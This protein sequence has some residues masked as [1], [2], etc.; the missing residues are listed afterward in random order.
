MKTSVHLAGLLAAAAVTLAACSSGMPDPDEKAG[1]GTGDP[2][3]TTTSESAAESPETSTSAGS[4]G[5]TSADRSPEGTDASATSPSDEEDEPSPSGGH[6][7]PSLE[8]GPGLDG[9]P[10]SPSSSSTLSA[11]GR[12]QQSRLEEMAPSV[13]LAEDLPGD[14]LVGE[15]R[16]A[17]VDS[18][19]ELNMTVRGVEAQGECRRLIT[20]IDTFSRPGSAVGFSQYEVNPDAEGA[21]GEPEAF[22]AA[23]ITPDEEDVMGMFG[24]LPEVCGELTG[25]NAT[26]VFEPIEGLPGA[27]RLVMESG[28]E[29]IE[30]LM[31]GASD[32]DEHVYTGYVNIETELAEQMLREQ[33]AAFEERK[34]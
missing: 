28:G 1:G 10:S 16:R 19:F 9:T 24:Q 25:P 27:S 21:I 29:R 22:A 13:L 32:G 17:S 14:V 26:A 18:Q 31:G 15:Q 34:R 20:R 3:G 6:D 33:V 12:E 8:A 2:E 23:V 30:L 11:A 5:E 7:G 4:G